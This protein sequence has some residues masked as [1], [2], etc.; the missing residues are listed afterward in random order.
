M[1]V[2][3]NFQKGE[4][5]ST[6]SFNYNGNDITIGDV[7]IAHTK[8]G[9]RIATVDEINP[10]IDFT[11]TSYC[12]KYDESKIDLRP[13]NF[14]LHTTAENKNVVRQ[15]SNAHDNPELEE[16]IYE[17]FDNNEFN[18]LYIKCIDGYYYITQNIEWADVI[19]Y[20]G[21]APTVIAYY[22]MTKQG[23]DKPIFQGGPESYYGPHRIHLNGYRGYNIG[24]YI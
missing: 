2:N 6:Y 22:A 11:P 3:V 8:Y 1:I 13:F 17:L 23:Y 24:Y 16:L 5:Y 14:N 18:A 20:K 4:N 12:V 10:K 7:V 15:I 19:I 21:N 9:Q